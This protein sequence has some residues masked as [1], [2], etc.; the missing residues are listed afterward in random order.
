[1]IR[2]ILRQTALLTACLPAVWLALL[3]LLVIRA[4][5]SGSSYPMAK[6]TPFSFHFTITQVFFL[7]FPVL[8]IASILQT[9]WVRRHF[10]DARSSWAFA[11][12]GI[13]LL[14]SIAVIALN[15]GGY[16]LWFFD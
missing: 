10:A 13:S 14:A 9:V 15:P 1:M 16:F 6:F 12:L 2:M 4:H 5:L 11:V 7:A 8:G 3:A